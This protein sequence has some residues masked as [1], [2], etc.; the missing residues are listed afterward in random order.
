M[1]CWLLLMALG[2]LRC[3][4]VA[5][6]TPADLQHTDD[7]VLLFL[8][9]Q[10]GGGVGVVPAHPSILEALVRLPIRGGTWWDCSPETIST[11]VSEHLRG[12]G[13]A[14][15]AHQ[16]RHHAGTSWYKA[17][18]HDLLATAALLRHASV[19]STQIYAETDPTRPRE[20]VN[21]VPLRLVDPKGLDVRKAQ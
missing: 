4:E 1:R 9:A 11:A 3:V 8:R 17:S 5:G 7:G 6:L 2:G 19:T 15:T 21:L 10:K 14:A 16:L 18:E 12:C 13:I 20:V